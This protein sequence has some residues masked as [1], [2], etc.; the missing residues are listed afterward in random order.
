[1][2]AP[3][4]PLDRVHVPKAAELVAA[5]LRRQIVRGQLKEG[6]ALPHESVLMETFAVSRPTLREAFRV[7]ESEQLI[8]VRRGAH[9]GARVHVPDSDVAARFTGLVLQHR[10]ATVADVLEARALIEPPAAAILARRG[11]PKDIAALTAT[12]EQTAESL[13]V[14]GDHVDE[15]TDFHELMAELAGNHTLAMLTRM[16]HHLIN[17]AWQE[18]RVGLPGEQRLA[19]DESTVRA[20]R[21][22]LNY[23]AAR[24]ADRA[25]AFWRKHIRDSNAVLLDDL[26][27]TKLLD[28]GM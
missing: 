7:L 3:A 1:M 18:H 10:G 9:G 5:S 22:F 20:H 8:R 17:T 26:G 27:P 4:L 23:V 13:R 12:L 15:H 25:E 19:E 2:A 14:P 28:L 11:D 16:L 24:D 6:D 21:K